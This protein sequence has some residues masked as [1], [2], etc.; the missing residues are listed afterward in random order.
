[1]IFALLRC[2][3]TRPP[4][5]SPRSGAP[6]PWTAEQKAAVDELRQECLTLSETVTPTRTG[7]RS[8]A[9]TWWT[10]RWN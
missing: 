10:S 7:S 4:Q 8:P 9:G 2:A 1:M 6:L 5:S 3:C